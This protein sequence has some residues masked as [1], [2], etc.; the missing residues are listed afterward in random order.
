MFATV[1][2][3]GLVNLWLVPDGDAAQAIRLPTGNVSF[4]SSAGNSVSWVPDGRIVYVSNE[5]GAADIWIADRDGF[6]RRQLTANN[7]LNFAPVVSADG[8]FVV[9]V[10]V[11]KNR[12]NLWRM[13][14]D[15]SNPVRLTSGLID[16]FPSI[17]PDS[18][19][20][21]YT[22]VEGSKPTLWKISID[23]GTP[24]QVTDHV[25]TAATISPDG[26]SI[27]Y[28]YPESSDSFA[29]PNRMALIPFEGGA[30]IKIF[31][32]PN[33]GTVL[34]LAQWSVDGKSI[35]YT[36]NANNVSNIW[37]QPLDGGSPKQITH[38]NDLLMTG[39]A[40]TPNGKLLACTRGAL[41]RDAVL[42]TDLK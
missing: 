18:R 25:A 28:T 17:S 6:N 2:A 29:P 16:L 11:Q 21:I 34:T 36:V 42:V 31:A 8:R 1:Q 15:G 10:S 41:V 20:V 27:V 33:S 12:R 37:S 14:L 4:Y 24:V 19:W 39:F 32:I 35:L 7:A 13:N 5:S 9:F 22:A 30:P 23:G 40:W 26:K 3:Q 38:F